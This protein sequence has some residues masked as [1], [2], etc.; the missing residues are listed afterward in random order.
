MR[1][2]A[3]RREE[4]L[5][6]RGYE[7]ERNQS[8]VVDGDEHTWTER[9]QDPPLR[10]GGPEPGGGAGAAAGAKPRRRCAA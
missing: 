2:I 5:I 7:F 4:E 9:V 10:V 1:L 6:G 8:A 3:I